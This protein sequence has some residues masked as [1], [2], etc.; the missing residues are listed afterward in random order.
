MPTYAELKDNSRQFL[1]VTSLTVKEFD[2]LLPKFREVY[3]AHYPAT[4]TQSG[5]SRQ[6]RAGGG[7][8]S[9]LATLEDKLLF[10]LM[11]QKTYPIQSLQG[12][13]FGLSQPRAN[14]LIQELTPLLNTALTRLGYSPE[15]DPAVFQTRG[16]G[17]ASAPPALQIDG[18]ERRRQRPKN[19][20]KQDQHYSGKKSPHG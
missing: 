9:R 10:I 15:R 17:P 11:Y 5:Q 12:L 18:T 8:K 4:R 19:P 14:E 2:K 20:E 16:A 3:A 6:R 7:R 13:T 1:A